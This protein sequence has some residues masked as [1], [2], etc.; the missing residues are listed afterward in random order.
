L[1]TKIINKSTGIPRLAV[2]IKNNGYP[3]KVDI[4]PEYPAINL[5]IKSII[6][7]NRAYCVAVNF[8]EVKEDK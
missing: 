3:K 4:V 1:P 7:L 2:N 5:G 6:E 8:I